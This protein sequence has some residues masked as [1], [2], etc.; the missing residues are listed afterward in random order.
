[1]ERHERGIRALCAGAAEAGVTDVRFPAPAAAGA[2]IADRYPA[3][4][5]QRSTI[6][7]IG[8]PGAGRVG[9]AAFG[10]SGACRGR[11]GTWWVPIRAS[12]SACFAPIGIASR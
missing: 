5:V 1:M 10:V 11:L 4:G 6:V 12:V 8:Y 7:R 3:I 2:M 9:V